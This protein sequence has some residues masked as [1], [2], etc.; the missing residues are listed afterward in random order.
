MGSG[1]ACGVHGPGR[2]VRDLWSMISQLSPD[3]WGPDLSFCTGGLQH[4]CLAVCMCK[5]LVFSGRR[6]GLVSSWGTGENRGPTPCLYV[7]FH[8]PLLVHLMRRRQM[9]ARCLS[10]FGLV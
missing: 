1:R 2:D 5:L 3:G 10:S 6:L 4:T 8:A 9:L 7:V